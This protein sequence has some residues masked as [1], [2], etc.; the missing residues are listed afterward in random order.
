MMF[1]ALVRQRTE[2]AIS[3]I[4]FDQWC[5][6]YSFSALGTGKRLGQLFCKYFGLQ[7]NILFFTLTNEQSIDYIRK[8]YV[9]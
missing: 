8:N 3:N 7:D 9:T 1:D 2:L 4:E 5:R 6:E